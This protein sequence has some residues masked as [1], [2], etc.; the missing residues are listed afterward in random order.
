MPASTTSQSKWMTITGWVLTVP[1]VLLLAM[2]ATM[3][4]LQ[5]PEFLKEFEKFGYPAS[6][7]TPIGI[8]EVISTV[9]FVLPPTR[10]LGAILLTGYL[11]GATATHVRVSD[12]W[13]GP[14][15]VGVVIWLALFFRD[16]RVRALAPITR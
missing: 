14:V 13:F 16:S 1:P 4:F 3:K 7:I 12:P 10:V 15:I 11:G 8:A 5:P 9:L 6:T 2:S